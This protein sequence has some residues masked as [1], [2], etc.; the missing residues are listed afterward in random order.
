MTTVG[1]P[2]MFAFSETDTPKHQKIINLKINN[3]L[4]ESEVNLKELKDVDYEPIYK[5]PQPMNIV[6]KMEDIDQIQIEKLEKS[7]VL[8]WDGS[9][10]RLN[11]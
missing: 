7:G 1:S 8:N 4:P 11:K 5:K 3:F 9:E 10:S 2:M 6:D